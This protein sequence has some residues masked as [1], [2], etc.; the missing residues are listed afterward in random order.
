MPVIL[1]VEPEQSLVDRITGAL[2]ATGWQVRGVG[3]VAEAL[4]F[5]A[6]EAPLLF[7][8]S[9]SVAGSLDLLD[10][11]ARRR[12]G[13][14]TVALVPAGSNPGVGLHADEVLN[15]PFP[16]D[17]LRAAVDRT[18]RGATR[19]VITESPTDSPKFTSQDIFGDL[20]ADLDD[21]VK[22][23]APASGPPPPRPSRPTSD[24]AID[25]KLEETLSGILGI[26]S[27]SKPPAPA[28]TPAAPPPPATPPAV[29]E[30][31][32]RAAGGDVEALLSRTL[33]GLDL[34]AGRKPTTVAPAGPPAPAARPP[35]TAP[36]PP[37]V[38]PPRRT[39]EL[40]FSL[41]EELTKTG[42]RRSTPPP[43]AAPL[44]PPP[45]VAPP[46]AA[47]PSPPEKFAPP[48]PVTGFEAWDST[49][50]G[51]KPSGEP[52]PA[53]PPIEAAPAAPPVEEPPAPEPP[54]PPVRVQV[55][56][57]Q[58]FGQYML[59]EKIGVGGM[60]EVWKA[61]SQGVEG[62]QK[63]VAIK[64]ILPHLTDSAD[65]VTMFVDEAKLAAQ[66]NHD[67]I[68][69]IFDL[70]KIGDDYY[71]AMEYVEGENLR[72]ILNKARD[73]GEPIP[74]AIALQI[75]VRLAGA[76]G[77]AHRKRD[78]EGQE[79]GL[80]HRDVSPQNVLVSYEGNVKLC[81]FGI[82]KA[83]ARTGHTQMGA[84]KGKLQY[85]SPEQAWGRPVDQRSD[86]FAVGV[87]LFEMLTGR[88]LFTGD[89]EMQLLEAVRD[90]RVQAP[91]EANPEIP[92]AVDVVVAK[93]LSREPMDRYQ[94]ADELIV[95]LQGLLARLRPEPV[96]RDVVAYMRALFRGGA[97]P[98]LPQFLPEPEP[99]FGFVPPLVA[100]A[101]FHPPSAELL[102]KLALPV[103]EAPAAPLVP[104]I[105]QEPVLPPPEPELV[106]EVELEAEPEPELAGR[107]L[108]SY[109]PEPAP[110]LPPVTEPER[111]PLEPNATIALPVPRRLSETLPVPVRPAP[112]E[113]VEVAPVPP[114]A[115][116]AL[117]ESSKGRGWLF[118]AIV[119]ALVLGGA[120][121]WYLT[122][123]PRPPGLPENA[124][125][126]LEAPADG[127]IAP[128][129]AP[130]DGSGTAPSEPPGEVAPA[131]APTADFDLDRAVEE[132]AANKE[133][134]LRRQFE[135]ESKRIQKEIE[136][137]SRGAPSAAA[138]PPGAA[139]AAPEPK[140]AVET[141]VESPPPLVEPEP[142]PTP[143]PVESAAQP[144]PEAAPSPPPPAP[145]A[146]SVKL[147]DLITMGP[148][149]TPPQ[150]VSFTK[151]QY[152]PLARKLRVTGE[153]VV[154]LLVDETGT[155]KEVR[156]QKGV[157]QNVG[158]NEAA[159]EAAR[160]ARYRP[161]AKE[162]VRV[163]MW[164]TLKIP[165]QL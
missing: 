44:A 75:A 62:F 1:V 45:P 114:L 141:P 35:V 103:S 72:A 34:P 53:P 64:R 73:R 152:P 145:V 27:P 116:V 122:R 7:V 59:L 77:Y 12:G 162:G 146:P 76:L 120:V 56:A 41:L 25:R 54:A 111:P 142:E 140:P 69:Q 10:P 105:P 28:P 115:G 136:A 147:G 126:S 85:M 117:E 15:H 112:P 82:V 23:V 9:T 164:T 32:R 4:E 138:P 128:D 129:G 46:V 144:P 67:N 78:F 68:I 135:A 49:P 131:D 134:E 11:F 132:K 37:A 18:L 159:L 13:P 95:A 88:R 165:F 55:A 80:V 40:D 50:P 2:G 104:Q 52:L 133:E 153:V 118:A 39:A 48:E 29:P 17:A 125:S 70:G 113:V 57:G 71:M 149:V 51:L 14:G 79:L 154:S 91:S 58:R 87:L 21:A 74:A 89:S 24:S 102:P 151:P 42:S 36:Q 158:L 148:G 22:S 160:T 137:A 96:L 33:S 109:L 61:R 106:A 84:L 3:S 5:T 121:A 20:V 63:T 108:E 86:L 6:S 31:P 156:L 65:F 81:D 143:A 157:N 124:P 60:A 30:P 97:D 94:T 38:P 101:S 83:V 8:V 99:A 123:T 130:A 43:A 107:T 92:V 16:D 47:P 139:K 98:V 19:R 66:L 110:L 90:C 150:L 93:A 161:A 119:A 26:A 127:E 163:K 155:V 100:A